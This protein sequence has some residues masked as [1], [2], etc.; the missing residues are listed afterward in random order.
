MMHIGGAWYGLPSSLICMENVPSKN[1]FPDYQFH[2]HHVSVAFYECL[3]CVCVFFL[4]IDS[5]FKTL[6]L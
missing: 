1:P 2:L 3:I 5:D 6:Q 4:C